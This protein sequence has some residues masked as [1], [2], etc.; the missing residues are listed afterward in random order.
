MDFKMSKM[1]DCFGKGQ[2]GLFAAGVLFG[3]AG[4]K[5]LTS[6]EAK[7][8]YTKCTAAGLRVKECVMK[9]VD[10]IQENAEDILAEAKQINE[11]R[12]CK[13]EEFCTVDIESEEFDEENMEADEFFENEEEP[14]DASDE[15]EN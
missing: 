3:T 4:L 14:E 11:E 5:L 15:S 6:P 9:T 10:L 8:V 13:G 2:C 1:K 12:A 7:N